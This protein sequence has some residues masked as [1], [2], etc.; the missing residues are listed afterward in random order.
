MTVR[1]KREFMGYQF[2]RQC[3]RPL[4]RDR[5]RGLC[6]RCSKSNDPAVQR[7]RYESEIAGQQIHEG[8]P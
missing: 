8:S 2:C 6:R 5:D 7:G 3:T 1:P 4:K